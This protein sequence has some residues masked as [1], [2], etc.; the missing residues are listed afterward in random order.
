[1]RPAAGDKAFTGSIPKTYEKYLVPLLF[2]PYAAELARRLAARKPARILELAAGTGVA[3]RA[4]AKA[5][6]SAQITATDLNPAM[7]ETAQAIGT[8]R[9]VEWQPADAMQLP[10]PDA[11]FDAVVCQFGVMFFPDKSRAHA[12]ARRVLK[13]GGAFLFN[14]WDRLTDNE[15]PDII[16]NALAKF[17]PKDPPRFLVRTPYGYNDRD[18]IEHDLRAGGF[19]KPRIEAVTARSKA[20]SAREPALGFCQGSPLRAEIEA[21]DATRLGEATEFAAQAIAGMFG[22]GAVDGRIQALVVTVE[23]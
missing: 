19:G 4:M 9:P 14:V 3:T 23:K 18:V 6:R 17:F 1:M 10:F 11:S 8:R 2:E 12:E 15:F 21:R 16:S 5:L 20:A 13:P 22:K 7:L